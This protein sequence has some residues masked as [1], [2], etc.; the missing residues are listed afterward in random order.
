MRV[1]TNEALA[2]RNRK[3]ATYTFFLTFLG[4]I[5]GFFLINQTLFTGTVPSGILIFL[6]FLV[7]P[8]ALV[9]TLV[10]VRMTNQW[11]R[12]PYPEDAIAEGL[13]GLSKKSILYNYHH[14]PARHV[15]IAP[16]GVFALTTRWHNGRYTVTGPAGDTSSGDAPGDAVAKSAAPVDQ[17]QS[18]A[19]ALS[20][21]FSGLRMDGI[22]NPSR[23]ARRHADAVAKT[24]HQLGIDIPVQP[25]VVMISPEADL[26]LAHPSVPIVYADVKKKPTLK[27]YLR[28]KNRDTD[29]SDLPLTADQLAQ[30]EAATISP[31][32]KAS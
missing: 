6:Q 26:T 12:R 4:L 20:R 15:L 29:T 30:F 8:I 32:K 18:H 25:L 22:G 16:Q 10:S 23:D 1:E 28:S 14:M 9:L 2:S 13:K 31:Q 19:S 17:W 11:S 5:G 27:D 7:L 24:F 21:V 3:I